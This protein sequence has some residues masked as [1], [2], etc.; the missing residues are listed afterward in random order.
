M[1]RLDALKDIYTEEPDP[2]LKKISEDGIKELINSHIEVGV[3]S[4]TQGLKLLKDTLASLPTLDAENMIDKNPVLARELLNKDL[5]EIK[6]PKEKEKL[7][8]LAETTIERNKTE[9][10]FSFNINQA[11]EEDEAATMIID[12]EITSISQIDKLPRASEEFKAT[13]KKLVLSNKK[14]DPA[15]KLDAL[16]EIEDDFYLLDIMVKKNKEEYSKTATLKD[17]ADYRIK[18]MNYAAE[19]LISQGDYKRWAGKMKTAFDT[20]LEGRIN[21]GF[22]AEKNAFAFFRW[23]SKQNVAKA[24][25]LEA[26]VFLK[27]RLT[28]EI[29]KN[30]DITGEEIPDLTNKIVGEYLGIS[31]D[32]NERG[33]LKL[34]PDSGERAIVYPD[35]SYRVVND[36]GTLGELMEV[37][38]GK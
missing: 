12:K 26:Q 27:N 31:P 2:T 4:K 23:W 32:V 14:V 9:A 11:K 17:F 5:I 25:R 37:K 8:K 18:L 21:A 6:D 36:D 35:N 16:N 10:A 33:V 28:E 1:G 22:I 20:K 29:E 13:A 24:Q 19:G 34:D 30:P 15:T 38:E 7:L 3:F